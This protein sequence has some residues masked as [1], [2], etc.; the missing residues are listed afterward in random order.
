MLHEESRH[1]VV[2]ADDQEVNDDGNTGAFLIATSG[3]DDYDNRPTQFEALSP[4]DFV[5][6]TRKV[7]LSAGNA[8]QIVYKFLNDHPQSNTHG[9]TRRTQAVVPRK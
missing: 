6:F 8:N 1:E 5:R 2:G 3:V 9:I 4:F 7:K